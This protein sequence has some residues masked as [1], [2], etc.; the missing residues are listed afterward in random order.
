MNH[1]NVVR[2]AYRLV[3]AALGGAC[4]SLAAQP[5]GWWFLVFIG[6]AFLWLAVWRA[7]AWAAGAYGFVWGL[8]YYYLTFDWAYVATGIVAARIALAGLEAVFAAVIGVMWSWIF[9]P[10]RQATRTDRHVHTVSLIVSVLAA[11]V[12]FVGV[13]TLRFRIP[14]GGLPW[15]SIAFSLVDSPLVYLAPFGSTPLVT[16]AAVVVSIAVGWGI[17]R[18]SH[19]QVTSSLAALSIA[20]VLV[21]IPWVFNDAGE[22]T[23]SLNVAIVQPNVAEQAAANDSELRHMI[24]T[25]DFAQHSLD[26]TR[27]LSEATVRLAQDKPDLVLWPESASEDDFRTNRDAASLIRAAS[28]SVH[29]PIL[30]GT[31]KFDGDT[32]R[33]DY[34]V[35]LPDGTLGSLY[36]KQH[37]VPFGEY[38]PMPQVMGKISAQFQQIK[39]DMIA[40]SKPAQLQLTA[41]GRQIRVAT[42]ICFE[43]AFDDV[44]TQGAQGADLIVVPTSNYVFG[45]S[46]EAAQQF[47]ISRFRAIE[48][49]RSVAQV[50]TAGISGVVDARGVVLVSSGLFQEASRVQAVPI[51]SGV[52]FADSTARQ[53]SIAVWVLAGI[54]VVAAIGIRITCRR[55]LRHHP[56]QHHPSRRRG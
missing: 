20:L 26:V 31:Q 39:P 9:M 49:R 18:L 17:F 36:S 33:N 30:L 56:S 29:V 6:V 15:G 14:F 40:G 47:A 11:A 38:L 27:R 13:E 37:P 22:P 42:P 51:Y 35:W 4:L 46:G 12:L 54:S 41:A 25:R 16:F 7:R 45:Y 34:V 28:E 23:S 5:H 24:Q 53:R 48:H 10:V 8:T 21:V 3:L 52:T 1:Q 55:P 2:G 19:G 50:S 43:V 44:V 32:R